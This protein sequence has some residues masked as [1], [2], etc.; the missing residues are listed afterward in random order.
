MRH[1]L[2]LLI[3]L[4]CTIG[5]VAAEIRRGAIMTVK[6]MSI[7]FEQ[8]AQ[9]EEWQQKKK[10]DAKAFEEYQEQRPTPARPGSSSIR[11]R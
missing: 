1:F 11:S 10:G 4:S 5:S 8:T 9:L 7:W 3:L 6:P 2:A